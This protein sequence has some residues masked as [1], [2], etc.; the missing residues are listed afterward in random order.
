M[1][2]NNFNNYSNSDKLKLLS[3]VSHEIRTPLHGIIGLT[4][5]LQDTTLN[6]EQTGL[7]EHLIHTERILM[8]LINDVLDYSKLKNSAFDIRLKPASLV[9]ILEEIRTLFAPLAAQKG[10]AL[11]TKINIISEYVLVDIL[12]VKQVLS[13]L[14]NNALK[15]T[16]KGSITL[17]CNQLTP[18]DDS[19]AHS[20]RFAVEDTGTGIPKGKENSIFEAYGQATAANDRNGT[21]LG[22]TIS[23]MI[24]NNMNSHLQLA[25]PSDGTK[26]AIFYFELTLDQTSAPPKTKKKQLTHEFAGKHALLVDDDPLVQ[27]ITASMLCKE[28]IDVAT[29]S[30]IDEALIRVK[31]TNPELIF[32]DLELGDQNGADLLSDIKNNIADPGH[33]ICMTASENSKSEILHLGFE[34]VLRKPFNRRALARVLSNLSQPPQ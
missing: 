28:E 26:G 33:L 13:N 8:N 5:Q 10:L 29:V 31:Q 24:L 9:G 20:Y 30:S 15:F 6:E 11:N 12:R 4:E 21:G 16:D 27:Q 1:Q 3:L 34:A 2:E 25:N 32:I 7:V 23:N 14:I 17:L 19:S 22:L 18:I